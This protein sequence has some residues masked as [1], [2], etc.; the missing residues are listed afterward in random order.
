MRYNW[1]HWPIRRQ[2]QII[3]T[4][5]K[6]VL[7][8]FDQSEESIA[9]IDFT[10][11]T[12]NRSEIKIGA[13]LEQHLRVCCPVS[14]RCVSFSFS[15]LLIR[16]IPGWTFFGVDI[17]PSNVFRWI[18]SQISL[19]ATQASSNSIL[20]RK[21]KPLAYKNGPLVWYYVF[22][23]SNRQRLTDTQSQTAPGFVLV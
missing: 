7:E 21:G 6:R 9:I 17:I 14:S 12:A 11:P 20:N 2:Y 13:N 22:M 4:N 3:L 5:Q 10:W 16:S 1:L 23:D 19:R 8:N 15:P 18:Y